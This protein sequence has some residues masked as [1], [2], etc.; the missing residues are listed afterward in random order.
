MKVPVIASKIDGIPEIIKNGISGVL[1]E[2][3][4]DL[5]YN[6]IFDKTLPYPEF[7]VNS[8][9]K[10]T[11]PKQLSPKDLI[12]EISSLLKNK[13][14]MKLVTKNL[15]SFVKKNNTVEKYYQSLEEIFSKLLS[16]K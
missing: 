13:D 3:K 8:E 10:L 2:P 5:D 7:V 15:Y 6:L 16:D 4:D 11:K 14:K 12:K 1:I 9:G